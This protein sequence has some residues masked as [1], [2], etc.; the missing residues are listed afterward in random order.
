MLRLLCLALLVSLAAA[1]VP[2][3]EGRLARKWVIRRTWLEDNGT[4]WDDDDCD[5]VLTKNME[6]AFQDGTGGAGKRKKKGGRPD[7]GFVQ[8]E[9]QD[10]LN[11]ETVTV[12]EADVSGGLYSQYATRW[13]N[14]KIYE[15]SMKGFNRR[16]LVGEFSMHPKGRKPLLDKEAFTA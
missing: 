1:T 5:V 11:E 7:Q 4:E 13:M 6:A 3:H 2:M 12:Y 9:V 16:K 10:S 15:T 14:G 8:L